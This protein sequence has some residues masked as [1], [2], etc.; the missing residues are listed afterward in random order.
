MPLGRQQIVLDESDFYRGMS[1]GPYAADGGFGFDTKGVN[2]IV[3]PGVLYA[4][5]AITNIDTG[6][7]LGDKE[8]IASSADMV[9]TAA[10]D[11]L[12]VGA[13]STD[14]GRFFTL[15]GTTLTAVGTEITT[16][17]FVKGYTDIITYRGEAYVTSSQ[18]IN[19]WQSDN[20]INAGGFPIN[21]TN[22]AVP[23]PAIVFEDNAY[24]GDRN[25]LL[26]Q[27]TAAGTPATILTLAVG[28][29]IIALGVD[30][31]SGKMLIS[32]T[33]SLNLSND[34]TAIN[35]LMWYDGFSNKVIKSI[36]VG[37]MVLGFHSVGG[38]TYCGYGRNL[39]L[40]TGSG[41][42]FL[43]RLINVTLDNEQLPYKHNFASIESTLYVVDGRNVLAY[44]PIRKNGDNV[45]YNACRNTENA[46]VLQSIFHSGS[47]DL[48]LS[49]ATTT[50]SKFDFT[51][52]AAG[53]FDFY[54]NW[55]HFPRPVLFRSAFVEYVG[56]IA[57]TANFAFT[58][59]IPG[60]TGN[61]LSV[62]GGTQTS[63]NVI[64]NIVGF[65]TTHKTRSIRFRIQ[66]SI[67]N[68]GLRKF[69]A[70]YDFVE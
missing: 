17:D 39:G 66:N 62:L 10:L 42:K 48:G 35:K 70:Y 37:D 6:T 68:D 29:I 14:D 40:V 54:T 31:S 21:F 9:T 1:S 2:P 52:T 67:E 59:D 26:R 55:Y 56:Q 8:I 51:S 41:I 53:E 63:I 24:Y 49:Y 12:C 3:E 4:P 38:V 33:S 34:R 11:R 64:N 36:Y 43:R 61:A 69:I 50:L 20:T 15:D 46:N 65:L 47:L 7:V 28:E 23:H 32:T 60:S 27:T 22:A 45:W 57:S 18:S 5:P 30:P 58:Y 19:R 16:Q 13:D 25:L 44:G